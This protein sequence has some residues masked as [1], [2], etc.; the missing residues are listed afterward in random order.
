MSIKAENLTYIYMPGTP[1]E[2]TA[3]EDVSFEIEQGEFV[4]IIGHT[5]SGKSTLIQQLDGLLMPTS[6]RVTVNGFAVSKDKKA[7]K[8]I[9]RRV[10]MVFQYPEHQ[11]FEET[12][13]K[14]VAFGPKNQGVSDEETD[15]RVREA[16]EDMGLVYDEVAELSPFE[17]SGGQKRRVAIAGVLA[18]N[19]DIIIFDEPTAGLDPR[20]REMLFDCIDKVHKKGKTIILVSHSMDDVARLADRVF[21]MSDKRLIFQGTPKEVFSE[22]NITLELDVPQLTKLE[23]MLNKTGK[24]NIPEGIFDA[25]AMAGA[26]LRE[27]GGGNNA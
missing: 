27:L 11:L 25:D 10:G 5:G 18:M 20:G 17:L 8:E 2:A 19:P 15:I 4:A 1:F 13:A 21:V 6:G 23:R 9:R 24:F 12:V 14:D 16:L 7:L 22:K 3:V 26:I